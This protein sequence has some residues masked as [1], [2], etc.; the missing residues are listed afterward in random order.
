MWQPKLFV[1]TVIREAK[2]VITQCHLRRSHHPQ[3]DS[4]CPLHKHTPR[5]YVFYF[6]LGIFLIQMCAFTH[7]SDLK[8]RSFLS[9]QHSLSR[10]W[11]CWPFRIEPLHLPSGVTPPPHGASDSD[12]SALHEFQRSSAVQPATT[13]SK[14][15]FTHA[16]FTKLSPEW[17][18]WWPKLCCEILHWWAALLHNLFDINADVCCCTI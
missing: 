2:A 5:E 8:L 16:A 11:C 3:S 14:P 18:A 9:T 10:S 15:F 13:T 1:V 6:S 7:R 17:S 4:V 12:Q